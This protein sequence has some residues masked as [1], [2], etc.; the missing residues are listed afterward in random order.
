MP[1]PM[2]SLL[3]SSKLRGLMATWQMVMQ[4]NQRGPLLPVWRLGS[5]GIPIQ[6]QPHDI[7]L[8]RL[9][10]NTEVQGE[11][12][13][14]YCCRRAA[15]RAS[16]KASATSSTTP[17]ALLYPRS[18]M[19]RQLAKFVADPGSLGLELEDPLNG[20]HQAACCASSICR[21]GVL[22][23]WSCWVAPSGKASSSASRTS[24]GSFFSAASRCK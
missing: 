1:L 19:Q 10:F 24:T 11:P 21:V 14:I 22:P 20:G 5:L 9:R 13:P 4:C 8:V 2:N 17:A 12:S 3:Y 6:E 16:G 15:Q 18:S 7:N 23:S